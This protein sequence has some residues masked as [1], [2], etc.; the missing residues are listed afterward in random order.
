MTVSHPRFTSQLGGPPESE[1]PL[2]LERDFRGE[3]ATS[4]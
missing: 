2:L 3:G 4:E 1:E